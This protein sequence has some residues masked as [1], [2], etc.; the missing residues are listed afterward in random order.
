M[1]STL[2]DGPSLLWSI[3]ASATQTVFDGGRIKANV[4]FA[5]SGYEVAVGN[6]RQSV[7][8]AMQEVQ[9][10]VS[11]LGIFGRALAD[12][13]TAIGSSEHS[14]SLATDRY[15]GGLSNYVDVI[16]AEQTVLGNR[17][18]AAQIAG[19]QM[20]AAVFLVK[21]LGGGWQGLQ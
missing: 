15:S 13:Q 11:S 6:Y 12:A 20:L 5:S 4:R 9:D 7:L 10:G 1:L 21:A 3:G 8:T 18:Q 16:N 14:L 17:R 2:L 19:Q